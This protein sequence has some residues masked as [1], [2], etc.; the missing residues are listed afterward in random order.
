MS[1][2]SSPMDTTAPSEVSVT[3][4]SGGLAGSSGGLAGST[5]GSTGSKL[6]RPLS[7]LKKK[8]L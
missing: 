2:I 6:L 1:K 5:T 3:G 4:S 8:E 7:M